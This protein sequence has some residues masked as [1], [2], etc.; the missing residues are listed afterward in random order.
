MYTDVC[1]C[2]C[3]AV[4]YV[5]VVMHVFILPVGKHAAAG[6]VLLALVC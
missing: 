1:L 3:P 2:V 5:Q 4:R 6:I